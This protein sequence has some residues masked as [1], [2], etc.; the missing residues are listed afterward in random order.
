[1]Y[2]KIKAEESDSVATTQD[3]DIV[4]RLADGLQAS[5]NNM[6][7][8]IGGNDFEKVNI[9]R[10]GDE[11]KIMDHWGAVLLVD[12]YKDKKNGEQRVQ[13]YLD[14][15]DEKIRDLVEEH[16]VSVDIPIKTLELLMKLF[17]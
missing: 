17:Q 14:N 2:Y 5:G 12:V 13:L 8:L 16:D 1:M 3:M 9:E 15:E 4:T 10:K 7:I 11:I 6:N